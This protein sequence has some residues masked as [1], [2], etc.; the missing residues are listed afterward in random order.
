MDGS[1]FFYV[2]GRAELADGSFAA[3]HSATLVGAERYYGL[4]CKVK[5]L[6]EGVAYHWHSAPPV[7]VAQDDGVVLVYAG[8]FVLHLGAGVAS[9]F[10]LCFF[11]AGHI[12]RAVSLYGVYLEQVRVRNQR[13][14]F[15]CYNFRF[16]F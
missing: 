8:E 13:L 4:A 12:G 15:L 7:R 11:N 9:E 1:S 14:Y 2:C 5:T 16:A 6:K 10:L 3:A